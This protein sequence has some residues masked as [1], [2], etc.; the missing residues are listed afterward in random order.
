[1][2]IKMQYFKQNNY[3]EKISRNK[4]NEIPINILSQIKWI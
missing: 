3:K 2:E 4:T 1:M